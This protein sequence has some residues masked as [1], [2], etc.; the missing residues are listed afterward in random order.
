MR[1]R[2]RGPHKALGE[3]GQVLPVWG[4]PP[5]ALGGLGP[6]EL[7]SG[8]VFVDLRWM[9]LS[10]GVPGFTPVPNIHP[11]S[12]QVPKKTRDST[13]CWVE[14]IEFEKGFD[15]CQEGWLGRIPVFLA[16]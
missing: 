9:A 6:S 10:F 5:P 13:R 12:G 1:P 11:T 16:I 14:F 4:R 3:K 15:L 2:G 8:L 7:S